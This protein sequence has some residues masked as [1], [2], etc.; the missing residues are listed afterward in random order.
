MY[1]C[2]VLRSQLF[3]ASLQRQTNLSIPNFLSA[4]HDTTIIV[5]SMH[6]RF[7]LFGQPLSIIQSLISS[8][9]FNILRGPNTLKD[10][11]KGDNYV[12]YRLLART[13]I[14]LAFPITCHGNR[15]HIDFSPIFT[16]RFVTLRF[17]TWSYPTPES[18]FHLIPNHL[19]NLN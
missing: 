6:R 14:F 15:I 19:P 10:I 3:S 4:P 11:V 1:N 12:N 17:P 9:T 13:K 16:P 5:Q 2:L 8:S 18:P 7:I